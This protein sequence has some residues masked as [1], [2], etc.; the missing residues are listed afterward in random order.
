MKVVLPPRCLASFGG[1]DGLPRS[2][3]SVNAAAV[4][5]FLGGLCGTRAP[6]LLEHLAHAWRAHPLHSQDRCARTHS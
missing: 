6:A 1:R 5:R 3:A 2:L 4:C